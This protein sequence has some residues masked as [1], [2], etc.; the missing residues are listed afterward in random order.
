MT[1]A[2]LF[3]VSLTFLP[4]DLANDGLIQ[5]RW[6]ILICAIPPLAYML[7]MIFSGRWSLARF[8]FVWTTVIVFILLRYFEVGPLG[9]HRF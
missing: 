9:F 4:D 2:A 6:A 5:Y 1:L 8:V 3:G 7:W